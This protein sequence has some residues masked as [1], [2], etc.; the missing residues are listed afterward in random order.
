MMQHRKNLLGAIL[1]FMAS[2][3]PLASCA[4]SSLSLSEYVKWV[5]HVDHG[6]RK[7]KELGEFVFDLQYKPHAY[8][9][10]QETGGQNLSQELEARKEELADFQYFNLS[11]Q[12]QHGQQDI[13]RYM[14]PNDAVYQERIY[15]FSYHLANDIQLVDGSDTLSCALFHF[16]RNYGLK[17]SVD[18]ALGFPKSSNP[19]DKQL[20]I[21][22]NVFNT[23]TLHFT[24][25]ADD[26]QAL[27]TLTTH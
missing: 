25:A 4:P 26:L 19:G 3:L 6:L 14:A 15:Y 8:I 27:P 13:L 23:G 20:I 2:L 17:P 24:I 21:Q 18:F 1:L 7:S 9:I 22:E 10:A 16:A 12:L 5:E 11:Y